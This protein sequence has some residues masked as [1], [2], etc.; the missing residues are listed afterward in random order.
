MLKLRFR[1]SMSLDGFIAGPNQGREH[2]LGVGGDRLH[3]WAYPLRAFN[4]ALDADLVRVIHGFD[5]LLVLSGSN[6]SQNL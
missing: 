5:S 3:E 1:I 2:P 6:P 4:E